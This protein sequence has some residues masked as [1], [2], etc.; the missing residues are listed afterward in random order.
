M[1][2]RCPVRRHDSIDTT[3]VSRF[4]RRAADPP[5]CDAYH[6]VIA[7]LVAVLILLPPSE[8]KA[9][10]GTGRRL[11]LSSALVIAQIALSLMLA[12]AAGL[13]VR[14]FAHLSSVP[15]GFDPDRVLVANVD[16]APTVPALAVTDSVLDAG[17]T[18]P[19]VTGAGAHAGLE[20]T[21]VRGAVAVRSLDASSCVLD[22]LVVVEHRQV[23]CL[24]YSYV[25]PG[26]RVPRRYHC[27]PGK[28]SAGS[29]PVYAADDPGSPLYLALAD[30]C[31]AA[32]REGGEGDAEMGVH[33]HLRRPLRLQAASR[34]LQPYLPVGLEIGIFGS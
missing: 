29:A 12:V 21:T 20:G 27:V 9:D 26:S 19:A 24:R 10:A 2:P 33:H 31:P 11:S 15:L 7:I 17:T 14:S 13:L 34:L 1:K 16:L 4:H 30:S 8:G 22:G 32:I 28:G 6:T 3:A 18:G 25:R 23:G 5:E